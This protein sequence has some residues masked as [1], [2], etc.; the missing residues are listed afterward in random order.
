MNGP[1]HDVES[2]DA[3]RVPD[4]GG[5]PAESRPE[6]EPRPGHESRPDTVGPRGNQDVEAE[7]VRRGEEKL[8][9]LMTH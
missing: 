5:D 8:D 2:P 9:R 6:G 1:Q 7:D 3:G 4:S